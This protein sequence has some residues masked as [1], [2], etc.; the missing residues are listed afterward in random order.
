MVMDRILLSVHKS[1]VESEE[2]FVPSDGRR[3]GGSRVL[4]RFPLI[5][6]WA[7]TATVYILDETITREVL[8]LHLE[9]AGSFIGVGRFRP[10]NNGFYGRFLAEI[11]SFS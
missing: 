4:K 6:K 11:V 7:S 3:G 8:Q 5:R 9:G 1:E 10:R 2:F